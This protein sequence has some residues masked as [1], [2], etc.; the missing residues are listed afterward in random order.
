[1]NF[2]EGRVTADG[3]EIQGLMRVPLAAPPGRHGEG[4]LAIRPERIEVNR[5]PGPGRIAGT[6]EGAAFL[7]Q[8]VIA[9]IG[10]PA[11]TRPLIA[12]LAASHPLS[13]SLARG[14]Q[15]H[16]SWKSESTWLLHD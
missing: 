3:F 10:V 6:V 11:L 1:M 5:E 9:H 14:L 12:R 8:D 15:V 13:S 2:I 16:C 7:G 4:I